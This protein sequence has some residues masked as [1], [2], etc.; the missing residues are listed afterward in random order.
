M[1]TG[2]GNYN[3]PRHIYDLSSAVSSVPSW[4]DGWMPGWWNVRETAGVVAR[5]DDE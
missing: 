2:T 5:N 3:S 4:V 1:L